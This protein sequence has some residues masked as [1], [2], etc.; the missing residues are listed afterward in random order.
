MPAI[1]MF[2]YDIVPAFCAA[3]ILSASAA[4]QSD[5]LPSWN[6]GPAK[7]AIM[8]FVH[9]ATDK[10]SPEFVPPEERIAAFDQDGTTWV[11]HPM[12]SQVMFCLDRVPAVVKA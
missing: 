11:E 4:A 5:P 3:I 8:D 6:E 12:Y 1:K 7:K 2:H 9:T 10:S